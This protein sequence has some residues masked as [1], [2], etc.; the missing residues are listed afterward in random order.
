MTE[1][2][3]EGV[4]EIVKTSRKHKLN[5][6]IEEARG[7]KWCIENTRDRN[8]Y[9]TRADKGGAVLVLDAAEVDQIIRNYLQNFKII[10]DP[11]ANIRSSLIELLRCYI[12]FQD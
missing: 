2:L 11:R 12:I 3:S 6:T 1:R 9:I 5:M 7:L 8:V 10:D 4:S